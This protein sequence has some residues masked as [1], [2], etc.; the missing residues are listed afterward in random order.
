MTEVEERPLLYGPLYKYCH[1]EGSD[2]CSFFDNLEI[3]LI[4]VPIDPCLQSLYEILK[5]HDW[6]DRD[7]IMAHMI[8]GRH[9]KACFCG[10][11]LVQKTV[12]L[13]ERC[14]IAVGSGETIECGK[15]HFWI[16]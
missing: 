5:L 12:S 7:E 1:N 11:M 6:Q 14:E 3:K 4:R 8:S 15:C 16:N 9:P 2:E 13:A 10:Q